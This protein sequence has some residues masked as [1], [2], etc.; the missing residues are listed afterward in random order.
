MK[1]NRDLSE[2]EKRAA[3]WWPD[4]LAKK[5][6]KASIIPLLLKTQ[7]NFISILNLATGNPKELF[8]LLESTKNK[9]TANVF[10][11]HLVVLADFGGEPIQRLN[12]NFSRVFKKD[13]K[14]YFVEYEWE[15]KKFK[16]Y[17]K[18]LPIKSTLNNTKLDLDGKKLLEKKE[19][20]DLKKDLII[21]LLH[22]ANSLY[23][24]DILSKCDIGNY[25]SHPKELREL[26]KQKYILVSRITGGAQ[27]NTLGQ[28]AQTYIKDF[29]K[30]KLPK[31]CTI[32]SPSTLPNVTQN[33][34][35]PISFDIV[36]Q[37]QDKYVAIEVSFQVTTNSV[38]ERKGGQAKNRF[39]M[40]K[41]KGFYIVYIIDGAGNFQRKSAVN[42]ICKNSHCTVA[43]TES[44]L[45]ILVK[46]IKEKLNG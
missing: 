17:F 37:N 19:L 30:K 29:L 21:I 28:L 18:G 16:Y 14:G 33:D 22:G 43:L 42:T 46:F 15:N 13:K 38:I 44:E 26:L 12:S 1:Y 9:L 27:S 40:I 36:I 20:D 8:K 3:M 11:K 35:T 39:T 23:S 4:F 2:L 25:I 5:E 7:D 31:S 34:K 32:K 10:L 24:S 6:S 45:S 41:K